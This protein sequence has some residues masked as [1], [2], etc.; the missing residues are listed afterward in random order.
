MHWFASINFLSALLLILLAW[1]S[2]GRRDRIAAGAFCALMIAM[3]VYSA[4]LGFE[5]LSRTL[6]A[7]WIWSR[8]QYAAIPFIPSLILLIVLL[9]IGSRLA[10]PA[11]RA[12]LLLCFGFSLLI[13]IA[14]WSSPLH[15]FYYRD[16][17]LAA[18]ETISYLRFQ[19]GG[20]YMAFYAYYIG[21]SALCLLLLT[22]QVLLQEGTFRIQASMV[23][24]GVA[25]PLAF[26]LVSGFGLT[27][28]GL[29]IIPAAFSLGALPLGYGLLNRGLL[30]I[31]PV[32][33]RTVFHA[34]PSG[35]LIVDAERRLLEYNQAALRMF[36]V[37]TDFQTGDPIQA[38]YETLPQ[39][40]DTLEK[41][42]QPDQWGLWQDGHRSF[43]RVQLTRLHH[44]RS[45]TG[46]LILFQDVTQQVHV[47]KALRIR[48]E[49]DG[50]TNV[51]NRR[52]FDEQLPVIL[53]EASWEKRDVSLVMF[54]IDHFK[55]LNDTHG[56]QTGDNMLKDTARVVSDCLRQGDIIARYGGEEFA[57]I[58]PGSPLAAAAEIAERM[59][60]AVERTLDITISLGVAASTRLETLDSENLIER[61]DL[62]LYAA[63]HN[64]R[65]RVEHWTP[66]A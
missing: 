42:T 20:L 13:M 60:A 18:H 26:T 41:L 46:Y 22:R 52:S 11:V 40:A 28:P 8:V 21:I 2:W 58:L 47:E 61:A 7:A 34:I 51:L 48:A 59:R 49:R 56:H 54:D 10:Q 27:P 66:Q 57:V 12:V 25:T 39:L 19:P 65:N 31:R 43:Y 9:F 50:L 35:C 14:H 29:D 63:K 1:V 44:F 55:N 37:L 24:L 62:A 6:T 64:G 36:P 16:I 38:L 5:S 53:H 45:L 32:A 17:Q 4:G 30:D 33:M 15:G 3:A 23:L